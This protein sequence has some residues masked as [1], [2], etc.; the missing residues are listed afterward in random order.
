MEFDDIFKVLKFWRLFKNL[1]N[2]KSGGFR[3]KFKAIGMVFALIF[4]G[5]S[6]LFYGEIGAEALEL[7]PLDK[8]VLE[9]CLSNHK[10][11]N[12]SFQGRISNQ[13]GCGCTAKMVTS[14]IEEEHFN[15]WA[16]AHALMLHNYQE[17]WSV[18][19]EAQ[20]KQ[21]E[22]NKNLMFSAL[23]KKSSMEP[24]LYS[25]MVEKLQE[26]DEICENEETY[27][28]QGIVKLASLRPISYEAQFANQ[29]LAQTPEGDVVEIRLRGAR[30]PIKTASK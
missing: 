30:A 7:T 26:I 19:S 15:T 22:K 25:E 24:K 16:K 10:S 27:S 21:F 18:T 23:Q 17:E 1:K 5:V 13:A 29:A 3:V 14:T 12:M 11:L 8:P 6:Y 20:Q 28:E 4:S 9:A 2:F